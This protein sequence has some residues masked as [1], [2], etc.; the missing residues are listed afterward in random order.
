MGFK[1]KRV[2]KSRPTTIAINH[3]EYYAKHVGKMSDGRQFFLTTPFCPKR[4]NNEGCEFVALFEFTSE[5]NF[6]VA[7]IDRFGPRAPVD[8]VAVLR[9]IDKRL[10]DLGPVSRQRIEV[11]PFSTEAFGTIFGLITRAPEDEGERWA[12]ELMPGNYMAFF[13]PWDSGDYDT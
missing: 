3:D 6:S 12:I 2:D 10:A 1:A 4:A 8:G 11:R 13:E 7:T 5:G 9:C